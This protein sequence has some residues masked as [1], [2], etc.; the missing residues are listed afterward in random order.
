[1]KRSVKLFAIFALAFVSPMAVADDWPAWRGVQGTGQSNEKTAPLKWSS[2][3]HIKW[4]V[5]LDGPGNS[6][7][8]VVG[9]YVMITHAPARTDLRGLRCYDRATG[10]QIWKHEV[11]WTEKEAT[12][13][14]NPPCASSPVVD[15]ERVFAW[16]GSAGLYCYD[17][18]GKVVWHVDLGRVEHI[19]G[20]GSS[21]AVYKDLV[22]LN[23]GPGVNAFVVAL[24]KRTGKEVWRREFPEQKSQEAGE[25]R[26]SWSTPVVLTESSRDVLLLSL[27][28]R[29]WAV[30]PTTGKDVWSCGGL[31]D[32][33]YTSPIVSDDVVVSMSGY[34]GPAMAVKSGGS[35]DV[36]ETHRLWRQAM[37][38]PPQ[39]VGSGA[40]VGG[41]VFIHNEPY[42]SCVDAKTGEQRWQQRLAERSWCSMVHVAGRLYVSNEAGTTFVLEPSPE[43]CK[44]LA[45][46]KLEELTRASIAVSDG[47]IFL[48][49][50]EHLYCIE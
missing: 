44:V 26:G 45:E 24:D 28:N 25:Y 37:P 6:S 47:Q 4:K 5:P 38:T 17:L 19:W 15:G 18:S 9:E 10:K 46:N 30:E 48:R 12:H 43:A 36:T 2:S 20:Y 14:T 13:Q 31:G 21:P 41:N 34:G 11:S 35:G 23:F 49:T 39:R 33:V 8:I 50:Y 3:E 32:L 7:P 42:A 29:L 27:P 1:M 16:Y 22:I 40:V